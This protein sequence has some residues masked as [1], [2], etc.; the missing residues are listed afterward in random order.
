MLQFIQEVLNVL[1]N[2]KIEI[3]P[4]KP[5]LNVS[6]CFQSCFSFSEGK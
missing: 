3:A 6:T 1:K 5:S 4:W 2:S